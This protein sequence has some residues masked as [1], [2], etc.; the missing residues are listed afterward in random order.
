MQY[1]F[2]PNYKPKSVIRPYE[3]FLDYFLPQVLMTDLG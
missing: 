3:N 2:Q 1:N